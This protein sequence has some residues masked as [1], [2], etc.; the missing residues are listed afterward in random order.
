M[1]DWRLERVSGEGAFLSGLEGQWDLP[2]DA[3]EGPGSTGGLLHSWGWPEANCWSVSVQCV[4]CALYKANV[5]Q[6]RSAFLCC[7]G[8]DS[9][10]PFLSPGSCQVPTQ[11]GKRQTR[12][13]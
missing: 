10:N 9:A 5:A 3:R 13:G 6:F 7:V 1:E 4:R 11:G 2:G 12:E 8:W